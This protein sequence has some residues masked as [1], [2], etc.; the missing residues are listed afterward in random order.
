MISSRVPHL[1][2]LSAAVIVTATR[3]PAN[4]DNPELTGSVV[5]LAA[6]PMPTRSNT[7]LGPNSGIT[8]PE[9]MTMARRVAALSGRDIIVSRV[10][11]TGSM[12]PFFDENALLL[13][14]AVPYDS[15]KLGDVVTYY[16]PTLKVTIVHRLVE[17]RGDQFWSRGD[18]NGG[19]DNIYV[20]RENYQR[21]LA[22]IIYTEAPSA[23]VVP[24]V[25]M[26]EAIASMTKPAATAPAATA[27]QP[28][29]NKQPPGRVYASSKETAEKK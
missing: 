19:L 23:P 9:G 26:P 28:V 1:I 25:G 10:A 18:H 7:A 5:T 16:H 11:P 3:A 6:T 13:L 14:E 15:L 21:R 20:T 29:A 4:V 12:K 2:F 27:R 17:K 8:P 24:T 22:G